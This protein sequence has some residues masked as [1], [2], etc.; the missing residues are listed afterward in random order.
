MGR[1]RREVV[2]DFIITN[3]GTNDVTGS[4]V[5]L[6]IPNENLKILLDFG[7]YQSSIK[8]MKEIYDVNYKKLKVPLDEITHILVTHAHYDHC[9]G[10]GLCAIEER[11]FTG[12]I[13]CTEPSQPLISLNVR[14]SA[15]VQAQQCKAY[16]K[17]NPKKKQLYPMYTEEH[18][19][20]LINY[21]QGY[22]YDEDIPLNQNVSFRFLP[23]GHLLGDGAVLL[24]YKKDEYTERKLLYTGDINPYAKQNRPYTKKWSEDV[25]DVDVLIMES[26]YSDRFHSNMD[27][28]SKL[29]EVLVEQCLR[30][31]RVLF[32][33]VFAIGRSSQMVYY[34]HRVFE[35]N[36]DLQKANLPIYLAGKMMNTSHK[37][38]ENEYFSYNFTDEE[39]HDRSPFKWGRVQKID[40]F[41]DVEE[42]LLDNKPK[43]IL[44]SSGMV[45]GGFS[46]FLAQQLIGREN[47]CFMT[48]GFQGVGTHGSAIQ[49]TKYKDK[50]E[51]QIQGAKYKVNCYIEEP[52]SL[53][54]HGD[55]NQ[56]LRLVKHGCSQSKLKKVIIIH[57]S[58]DGKQ[59]MKNRIEQILDMDKKEVLIP[60][61]N[62]TIRLFSGNKK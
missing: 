31:K 39:W 57:G 53:S 44:S 9:A 45:T 60:K 40:K 50:K 4:C 25:L 55:E 6:E 26:T 47:V 46:T 17:A 30:Q 11:N 14:D 59:H 62:E 27:V 16:N 37:V 23:T 28:E 5:M 56:L 51:V 35:R 36:K 49:E 19:I 33:P 21:L 41:A 54:G 18:A 10:L 24:T 32:I 48:C 1:K 61:P 8:N 20:N 7:L 15:F 3:Y 58:D 34:L 13:M 42:K 22:G 12:K 52:L 2:S 43:I 29:E 38:Y